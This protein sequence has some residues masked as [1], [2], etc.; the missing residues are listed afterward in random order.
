MVKIERSI[1]ASLVENLHTIS[2]TKPVEPK[3]LNIYRLCLRLICHCYV[4]VF[5]KTKHRV[6]N[7]QHIGATGSCE[8]IIGIDE[9]HFKLSSY[10][11]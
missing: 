7:P 3:C 5:P 10:S 6:L 2:R 11:V 1:L 8:R 9:K 4:K